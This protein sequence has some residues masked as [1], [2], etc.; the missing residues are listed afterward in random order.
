MFLGHL[1]KHDCEEKYVLLGRV[2]GRR[3]GEGQRLKPGSSLVE[4][5]PGEMTVA[6]FYC[7]R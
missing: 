2:E 4:D 7:H 6:V 5:I 1:L 3:A